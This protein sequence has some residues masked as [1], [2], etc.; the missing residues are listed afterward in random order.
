MVKVIVVAVEEV[1]TLF[2]LV[3]MTLRCPQSQVLELLDHRLLQHLLD[4]EL[5]I[6]IFFFHGAL[7]W[8]SPPKFQRM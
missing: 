7:K 3:V 1:V 5:E 2:Q 4:H 6:Q 8:M